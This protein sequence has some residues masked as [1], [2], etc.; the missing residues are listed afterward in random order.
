MIVFDGISAA[1]MRETALAA[2]VQAL[3]EQGR[4]LKIAALVFTEDAGS[5][6]Y[7]QLKREAAERV[8]IAYQPHFVSISD[9]VEKL[10][11]QLVAWQEDAT[12]TGVII[13]KPTKK[14]WREQGRDGADFA[15][16]W[17]TLIAAI[18]E[19]KDVD[20]LHPRTLEAVKN[21]TWQER[22]KVLPATCA[23]VLGI[24][25]SAEESTGRQLENERVAVIGRSDLLGQPLYFVLKNRGVAVELL[26]R[27]ELQSLQE[28][29]RGLTD[30]SVVV[31]ATG[32]GGLITAQML[33]EN[34]IVIDVGEPRAD[35]D[36]ASLEQASEA[37]KPA[38]LTPVPG[39]V[40]PLT[41]ISLLEN[42]VQLQT[43]S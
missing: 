22:G 12:I 21:N 28:E 20:G 14:V 23:A 40:G 33:A 43:Q 27:S 10:K 3:A 13:Q 19:S 9:D 42:A 39:G 41:V 6:L 15:D 18:P 35:L 24:L 8:G 5:R 2:K 26:G 36:R 7:T 29:G 25:E 34:A 30:F 32:R 38:F 1:R 17:E 31:S 16:W 37:H 4:Q 11:A